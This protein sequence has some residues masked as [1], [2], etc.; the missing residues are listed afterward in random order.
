MTLHRAVER[1][2]RRVAKKIG[3]ALD[4][5]AGH[6]KDLALHEARK[7]A[8]RARYT[9][10]VLVPIEGQRARRFSKRMTKI[11]TVLGDHQDSVIARATIRD[12]GVSAHRAGQNA[13]TYGLLYE[14][15]AET[16]RGL[17]HRARR[18]WRKSSRARYRRW[19]G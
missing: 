2:Y 14:R 18:A 13:F 15:D 17:Q 6:D 1:A 16:A 7:A 8:K 10:D 12:L 3:R 19:L 5:P 9:A 4:M 11:Q